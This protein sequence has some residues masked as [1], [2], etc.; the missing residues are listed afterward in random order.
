MSTSEKAQTIENVGKAGL[1]DE[2]RRTNSRAKFLKHIRIRHLDSAHA[3]EVGTMI[4]L[5]RDGLYFTTRSNHFQAGMELRVTLP[6]TGAECSCEVVRIEQLQN[7]R[8]GI[9]ARIL[10]W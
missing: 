8:L 2:N 10:G 9:G 3:D 7:G 5:S 1:L 4:D 6:G